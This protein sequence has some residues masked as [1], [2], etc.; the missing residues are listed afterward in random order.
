VQQKA[1]PGERRVH[2]PITLQLPVPPTTIR[3]K[4]LTRL[5]QNVNEGKPIVGGGAGCGISAKFEEAGGGIA[6]IR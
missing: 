4:I 6:T 3:E 5:L 2:A 1:A